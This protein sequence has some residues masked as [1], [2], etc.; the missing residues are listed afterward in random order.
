M[1]HSFNLSQTTFKN[2]FVYRYKSKNIS[3]SVVWTSS[4][5]KEERYHSITTIK[6]VIS[7]CVGIEVMRNNLRAYHETAGSIIKFTTVLKRLICRKFTCVYQ[8]WSG[9]GFRP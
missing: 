4:F 3:R 6:L 7:S 5:C 2:R 9:V 8:L 1:Q